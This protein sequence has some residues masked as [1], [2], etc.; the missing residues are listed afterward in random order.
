MFANEKPNCPTLA[1]FLGSADRTK[2]IQKAQERHAATENGQL[3]APCSHD[4]NS[5]HVEMR[6]HVGL[7]FAVAIRIRKLFSEKL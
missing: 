3:A 2:Y 4:L 6:L 5:S 1:G 7:S